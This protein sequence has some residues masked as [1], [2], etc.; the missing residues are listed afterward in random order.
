M[1]R[2]TPRLKEQAVIT[3]KRSCICPVRVGFHS[4]SYMQ[5]RI[6]VASRWDTAG[7]R[8]RWKWNGKP[9]TASSSFCSEEAHITPFTCHWSD[10]ATWPSL[11]SEEQ[12]KKWPTLISEQWFCDCECCVY[13][14]TLLSGH[15]WHTV[16]SMDCIWM[17]QYS[18]LLFSVFNILSTGGFLQKLTPLAL[19]C[20][21]SII[22]L[23]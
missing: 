10:Q 7:P 11:Q 3:P 4:A 19:I 2:T 12:G 21:R 14:A 15:L 20:L 17:L 13:I 8:S 18:I 16:S 22:H 9:H 23:I 5:P 1:A 6:R